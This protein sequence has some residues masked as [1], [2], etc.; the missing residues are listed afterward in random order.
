MNFQQKGIH[1]VIELF[2]YGKTRVQEPKILKLL[3]L[4]KQLIPWIN[5]T[6]D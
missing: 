6:V 1:L 2:Q 5:I 3:L 4:L